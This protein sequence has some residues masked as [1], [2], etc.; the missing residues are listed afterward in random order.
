MVGAVGLRTYDPLIKSQLLYQLSYAP[1]P[2]KTLQCALPLKPARMF[3]NQAF[4]YPLRTRWSASL[5]V[6]GEPAEV[7]VL[8]AMGALGQCKNCEASAEL[9][10][11]SRRKP[12]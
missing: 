9:P 8:Q 1:A 3:F 2:P 5:A 12:R 7:T 11:D 6:K 10:P 4:Q